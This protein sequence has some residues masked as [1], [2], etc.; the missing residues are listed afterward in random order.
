M[1]SE[2]KLELEDLMSDIKKTAN[3]VRAKL[4]GKFSIF[5]H[6]P[7]EGRQLSRS[8]SFSD[9]RTLFPAYSDRAE[10]R[11]RG[12]YEQI[13]GGSEDT[14]DPALDVVQ[15]VRRGDDGIQS[16]TD[17]LQGAV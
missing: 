5:G 17:R 6:V 15:E 10:H 11:A 7:R 13:V 2:V 1:I 16:D 8:S 12:A 9:I 4:K 3:K 14:Q